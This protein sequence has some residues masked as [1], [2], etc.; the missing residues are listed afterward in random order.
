MHSQVR[1]TRPPRTGSVL[2]LTLIVIAM[3]TLGA[4]AF[5]QRMLYEFRG[6]RTHGRHFQARHLAESGV[7]YLKFMLTQDKLTLLQSGGVYMNPQML[8]GVLI[9]P[10]EPNAIYRGRFTC[11]APDMTID[12]LMNGGLR[13]G[14][15]ENESSRLN[16][17][18]V[19]LAD[20]AV[21][22]SGRTML[23]ALPGMTEAIADAIL[24][25]IDTDETPREMGAELSQYSL[26]QFR[27]GP[28]NAALH[29]L[30]ELLLVRDVTPALLF[31]ADLNRDGVV[32]EIE[33]PLIAIDN[34]DNTDG[35][36]S[37]GWSAYLTID[38]AE[39]NA[40]PDGRPKIDVNTADLTLLQ[41]QLTEILSPD[42]VNF[43]I[44]Y[45]QGGVPLAT[46]TTEQPQTGQPQGSAQLT[47]GGTQLTQGG[48][49]LTQ[50]GAQAQQG[51][52][53]AQQGGAQ[54][55]QGGGAAAGAAN[56]T[57][58][59]ASSVQLD[60]ALTGN[61][62]LTSI[63]DLIGATASVVPLNQT[64][65]V[66][67]INPFI[68]DASQMQIY[69]PLLMDNVAVNASPTI[70][71][72]LNIN[73]APRQLLVGIPGMDQALLELI[74]ANRDTSLGANQPTQM[75][76][77]WLLTQG[78][79]DLAKMKTLLPM[80]TSGGDVYRARVVGYFDGGGPVSRVEVVIDAT[81][82]PPTIIRRW[83]LDSLGQDIGY[84]PEDLGA[85]ID[86]IQ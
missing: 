58:V 85:Q 35:S 3:L 32:Q 84:F 80:I 62:S 12:G 11:V 1:H 19:L 77:T 74:I 43:I 28:R 16:L 61:V 70:P 22:G 60:L 5:S 46:P 45:R 31:G 47:Q 56:T 25:W 50:G 54:A 75:Y 79:V 53:Q 23:M 29:S 66:S 38:S 63:L 81:T 86:N 6:T 49:Q 40:R 4:M 69:L 65:A 48:T 73:Q 14:G 15:I 71:G 18:A 36:L 17:N 7:E 41:Q 24:D 83:E 8:Q 52:A 33:K 51:G 57:P 72:R 30:E 2:V 42:Q 27:Y 39:R 76:E 67:V 59:A 20:T 37:R 13:Y 78:L 9:T 10:E 55:Q 44:A 82:R 64:Q 34:A 68:E 21:A 26:A